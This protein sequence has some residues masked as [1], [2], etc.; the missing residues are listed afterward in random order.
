MS[1]AYRLTI[2]GDGVERP[3]AGV[4]C[5]RC[6]HMVPVAVPDGFR[7]QWARALVERECPLAMAPRGRWQR[8]LLRLARLAPPVTHR[9]L[10][11]QEQQS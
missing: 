10:H 1:D 6:G 7:W 8:V 2:G 9:P 3:V 5:T 4:V 11:V